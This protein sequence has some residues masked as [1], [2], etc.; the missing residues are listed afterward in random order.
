MSLTRLAW[1]LVLLVCGTPA[2]AA[3]AIGKVGRVQGAVEGTVEGATGALAPD[4]AVF[5]GEVIETGAEGRAEM[6]L[7]DGTVL[8][9]GE[10][11]RLTLDTFVV[12]SAG[13]NRLAVTVAGAFR[14]VS[15]AL[16]ASRRQASVTTPF[17]VIG[18]RGTDF[19]G[20]PIDGRFGVYL[21]EGAVAVANAA[22]E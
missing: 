3:T 10:N 11:A 15:A 14:F 12:G 21:F 18:V 13:A 6:A 9:I 4:D 19:W 2:D 8:T 1:L 20:G 16:G 5:L 22:G 17:A 7:D